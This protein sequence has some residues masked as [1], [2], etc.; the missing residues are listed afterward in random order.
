MGFT[1]LVLQGG[2]EVRSRDKVLEELEQK[3]TE[4][5][6]VKP[7]IEIKRGVKEMAVHSGL[8]PLSYMDTEFDERKIKNNIMEQ[9]R[10]S[11]RRF[12]MKQFDVYMST[13]NMIISQIRTKDIPK[14]S[15]LIG[16]PNGLGKTSFVNTC[17]KIMLQNEWIATPYVSLFELAEIRAEHERNLINSVSLSKWARKDEEDTQESFYY[18]DRSDC[19]K[20]PRTITNRFS[21]SEYMNSEILFCFFSSLDNKVISSLNTSSSSQ[22]LLTFFLKTSLLGPFSIY[23]VVYPKKLPSSGE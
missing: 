13:L 10:S 2:L 8:I 7:V 5:K 19:V 3:D 16:A 17:L 6:L 23:L 4:V 21:W 12:K 20:M 11:K 22:N 18:K 14:C 9:A 15:Y 1:D